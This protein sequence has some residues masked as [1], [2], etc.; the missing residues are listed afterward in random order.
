[1]S[2][3][4][5]GIGFVILG[6]LVYWFSPNSPHNLGYVSLQLRRNKNIWKWSNRF[7][8]RLCFIGSMI[9]LIA[10]IFLKVFNA[11]ESK[12]NNWAMVIFLTYII[13]SVIITEIYIF[14]K[15][16]QQKSN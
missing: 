4:N 13:V 7:F 11:E 6:I 8:G 3:I 12:I 2:N 15:T 16:Q 10:A 14:I 1:M 9:F 5:L